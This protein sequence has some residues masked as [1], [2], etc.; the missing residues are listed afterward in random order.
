MTTYLALHF[1]LVLILVLFALAL[2]RSDRGREFAHLAWV[3][4]FV[5]LL[6]PPFVEIP[7]LAPAVEAEPP[8]QMTAVGPPLLLEGEAFSYG[9]ALDEAAFDAVPAARARQDAT[10]VLLWL[11]AAGV[12]FC[13][14]RL[15]RSMLRFRRLLR[16][17]SPPSPALVAAADAAAA[18]LGLAAPP[19]LRV[20]DAR[21][22]PALWPSRPAT[23]VLPAGLVERLSS[24]ELHHVLLH[25]MAHF[26]RKDHWVRVLEATA[27]I[28]YWWLPPVAWM[29]SRLRAAEEACC[30]ARVLRSGGEGPAYA[31]ALIR[32]VEFLKGNP[33]QL[34]TL[35][36]SALTGTSLSKRITMIMLEQPYRPAGLVWRSLFVTGL[37][38]LLPLLPA[39]AEA[40]APTAADW[41]PSAPTSSVPAPTAPR[42][43]DEPTVTEEERQTLIEI[44]DLIAAGDLV[45]ATAK[46]EAAR[47]PEASAAFDFTAGNLAL[48]S[49][50]LEAAERDYGIA[51]AKHPPLRRAW[52]NLGQ[53][54]FRLGNK[55][56]AAAAFRRTIELGGGDAVTYGLLATCLIETGDLPG[57]ESAYLFAIMLDPETLDWRQGLLRVLFRAG[58]YA[59]AVT[60]TSQLIDEHPESTDLLL[61]HANACIALNQPDRASQTLAVVERLGGATTESRLTRGDLELNAGRYEQGVEAYRQALAADPAVDATRIL[62]AAKVLM[63]QGESEHASSLLDSLEGSMAPLD[64]TEAQLPASGLVTLLDA[65]TP[66]PPAS[67]LIALTD[68]GKVVYGGREIGLNGVRPLV[69]RLL[70]RGDFPVVIQADRD[71][72]SG[73]LVRVIDEAKLGGASKLNIATSSK[74]ADPRSDVQAEL[75][76][77]RARIAAVDGEAAALERLVELDPEN[78]EALLLLGRARQNEGNLE[79]ALSCYERAARLEAFE[80]EARVRQGQVLVEVQRYDE[81]IVHLRRAQELKPRESV[82]DYLTQI[83][84]IVDSRRGESEP[85]ASLADLDAR[86]RA[87]YQPGPVLTAEL[88][89]KAPGKGTVLF[90]VDESGDVV[91]ARVHESSNPAFEKPALE[92]VRRWRFQPAVRDGKPVRFRMRTPLTF[93]SD[94]DAK[95]PGAEAPSPTDVDA[96]LSGNLPDLKGF[97]MEGFAV[98]DVIV[99]PRAIYK[100]SAQPTPE[101]SAHTPATV[102]LVFLVD[103]KG[104][105]GSPSVARSTDPRFDRAA[106]EAIKRW[107]FEPGTRNGIPVVMETGHAMTFGELPPPPPPEE[108]ERLDLDALEKGLQESGGQQPVNKPGA[109]RGSVL[110]SDV[111]APLSGCEITLLETGEK[112]T[113]SSQGAYA[114][115]Q[116]APGKHTLSFVKEGYTRKLRA[117]VVVTTGGLTD[118]QVSLSA[119]PPDPDMEEFVV[120]EL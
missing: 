15:L 44:L 67:I 88:R 106:L 118:V 21:V 11:W 30:D 103:T 116:V 69:E 12:V 61:L 66:A 90:V 119:D 35:A 98:Q 71:T 31:N 34:P 78:G 48:Q 23:L 16:Y 8:S 54:H 26:A 60:L 62:R 96:D 111:D 105:V 36:T 46:V 25:E 99:Q 65:S 107:K 97:V 110:D 59:D 3:L 22:S 1:G 41:S 43:D 24:T 113:T 114:F 51:V 10:T 19:H 18:A 29:R 68:D 76:S 27:V 6:V 14:V 17:A 5:K 120:D 49:E 93:P 63:A 86:P 7:V 117:D 57:A 95:S 85:I 58:R 94:A 80:A 83:E 56:E 91:D 70:E 87:L 53:V 115:Q 47:G 4:V 2:G 84:R 37:L 42:D 73:L 102:Q 109:I 45:A 64:D 81:A 112:T 101:L 20:V 39:R 77:L 28:A 82:A 55:E 74:G 32:A 50:Q 75:S 89:T 13:S 52:R 108:A 100:V 9:A 38:S 40:A 72:S 33:D 79:A 104:G 92:A